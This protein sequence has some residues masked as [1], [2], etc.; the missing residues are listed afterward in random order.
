[1]PPGLFLRSLHSDLVHRYSDTSRG[2][3]SVDLY[4]R[5]FATAGGHR[6]LMRHLAALDEKETSSVTAGLSAMRQPVALVWGSSDRFVPCSLARR[7][8]AMLPHATLDILDDVR[9]FSPEEAPERV[10]KIVDGLLKR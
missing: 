1:M 5:P 7:L 4:L 10:A 6:V 9:H 3:H 2:R 8:A